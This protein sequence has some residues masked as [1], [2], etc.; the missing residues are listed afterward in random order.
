MKVWVVTDYEGEVHGVFST[1]QKAYDYIEKYVMQW[2]KSFEEKCAAFDELRKDFEK[3]KDTGIA[4][5]VED[6]IYCTP[7]ILD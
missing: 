7:T 4:W 6:V 5:G 3:W 2:S 1:I